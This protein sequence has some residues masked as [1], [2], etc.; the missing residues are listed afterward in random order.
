[1]PSVLHCHC[2]WA[3]CCICTKSI[4]NCRK[5][6]EV[7]R[8]LRSY[9]K[10]ISINAMKKIGAPLL[11]LA[12][13]IY[14]NTTETDSHWLLTWAVIWLKSYA[15]GGSSSWQIQQDRTGFKRKTRQKIV[16]GSR[17]L[18][19]GM[20][21]TTPPY[22]KALLRKPL[23]SGFKHRPCG[24]TSNQLT[25]RMT[26]TGQSLLWDASSVNESFLRSKAKHAM[27]APCTKQVEYW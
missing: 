4:Y 9:D 12:K 23:Q 20:G 5:D 13:Y 14:Y 8:L 3:V 10:Q 16:P 15:D 21:S 2:L 17:G 26:A 18:G 22:K 19:L 24:L 27:Y 1:M 25:G 11:G 6:E 7:V